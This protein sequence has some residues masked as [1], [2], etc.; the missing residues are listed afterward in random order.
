MAGLDS[1]LESKKKEMENETIDESL[2]EQMLGGKEPA[3]PEIAKEQ[4]I[5]SNECK[6]NQINE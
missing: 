4:H 2:I 6:N 3:Q 5:E 1:Y